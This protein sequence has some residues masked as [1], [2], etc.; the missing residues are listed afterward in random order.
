[1]QS[2]LRAAGYG[3]IENLFPQKKS[4]LFCGR[5]WYG[6]KLS[7]GLCPLCLIRWRQ[8]RRETGICPLCG[9]FDSG[10]PCRGPCAVYRERGY[11]KKRSLA[12]IYAAAPYTGVY[13]QRIMAFKYNGQPQLAAPLAFL[14]A[15]A[16]R[17]SGNPVRKPY[18]VPVPMHR[19]KQETRGYNQSKLLALALSRETGFPVTELLSRPH[20]GQVQAGLNRWQRQT[21][22][23]QVFRWAGTVGHEPG[24]GPVILVDDVL[25]TGATLD[26]CGRILADHGCEP[27][28][29][30]TF[31][32]GIGA[33]AGVR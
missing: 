17:E 31:A 32:G 10:D 28:W 23:E 8:F 25:T 12:A 29:G 14:M 4:C 15:A 30:L 9:S 3:L 1:M 2:I 11:A 21:A 33:G 27:V 24:P 13:R 16:W 22:L 26:S 7:A 19:E 18:L 5:H 6:S 20:V